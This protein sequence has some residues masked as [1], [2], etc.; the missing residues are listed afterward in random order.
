[1]PNWRGSYGG[2]RIQSA[3]NFSSLLYRRRFEKTLLTRLINEKL[4]KGKK[5]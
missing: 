1:V 5:E 2:K 4:K 3:G